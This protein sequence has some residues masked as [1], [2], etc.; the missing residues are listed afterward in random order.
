MQDTTNFGTTPEPAP[1]DEPAP[2]DPRHITLNFETTLQ[3]HEL[4]TIEAV[5]QLLQFLPYE[6]R[7]RALRYVHDRVE[8]DPNVWARPEPEPARP[9]ASVDDI[10]RVLAESDKVAWE[11]MGTLERGSYFRRA[12]ALLTRMVVE[13]R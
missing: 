5:L 4:R 6:T 2:D 12:D 11:A 9:L 10:A 7:V 13:V 3:D 1:A 8:T